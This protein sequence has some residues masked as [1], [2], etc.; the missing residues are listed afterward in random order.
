MGKSFA[1]RTINS[2]SDLTTYLL[3]E[4]HVAVVAGEAFGAPGYMRLSYATSEERIIEGLG[5]I[6]DVLTLK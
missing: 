6:K 5:R 2:T 1:G 3:E 4:G